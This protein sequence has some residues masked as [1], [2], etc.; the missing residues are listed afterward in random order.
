[1]LSI[2]LALAP[3]LAPALAPR[4]PDDVLA[5]VPQPVS[6]Q[7][8]AGTFTL[9]AQTQVLTE[10][11]DIGARSAAAAFVIAA[12][13]S[14]GLALPVHDLQGEAPA[15]ALLFTR[16]GGDA[17]LGLEGYTLE[18]SDAGAV[19]RSTGAAGLLHGAETLLQLFPPE[20]YARERQSGVAWSAPG[21]LIRDQP[22]FA[23]RG[24]LLDVSR[25]FM[26]KDEVKRILDQ[27]ALH[28]LNVFHWH[29]VDDHG[30]RIEIKAYP[31][32]TEVGAWRSAIGF[33]LDPKASSAYDKAGRYGGFYTQEDI[34]EIV[35]FAT[36]RAIT[37]VPEIEMPGHSVAA[38][39]A[40][41]Q[42]SCGG[43]PFDVDV[44][45]GVH[46]GIFCPGNEAT[47]GFLQ[48]VLSE[49]CALFPGTFVHLGGDEV[50]REEWQKCPRCLERMKNEKLADPAELQ[51]WFLKRIEKFVNAKGKRVIGWDEI[52]EGGLAPNAA[53]MSWRG[54]QGGLAAA[55]A[56][57]DVV[58]C[59]NESLY[60]DHYQAQGGEP[61]AIGGFTPIEEV[62]GY[63]PVPEG[64]TNAQA[65]H[66]LGAQG[67]LWTEYVPNAAHAEY[68][69][70]PR[71][72]AVAEICWTPRERKDLADFM[73]RM[74]I[75]KRR[76]AFLGVHYRPM[77]PPGIE[78][79]LV[80]EGGSP[81]RVH[82]APLI[83]GATV[84]IS[85]DGSDPGKAGTALDGT[86]SLPNGNCRV[87]ARITR[88]DGSES[89]LVEA[90]VVLGKARVRTP[91]GAEGAYQLERAFDL[92]ESSCFWSNRALREGDH[93]TLELFGIRTLK[94]A[95]VTTGDAEKP[96]DNLQRG[97]LEVLAV[98][99]KWL[100]VASFAEG[101]VDCDLPQQP[102][103]AVR[104]RCTESQPYWLRL[105]E[106]TIE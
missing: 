44:P 104:I 97:V 99:G 96:D 80:F 93:V 65:R 57:H 91:L 19:V 43:G 48:D 17:K 98:D 72:C 94:H 24:L 5:L 14:T 81:P 73:R 38:L 28:K 92:D 89:F 51:S 100:E 52:L 56:G 62:Y 47:F 63:E 2:V 11:G 21:V 49:V 95:R 79:A 34:R 69:L 87:R 60:L 59:P 26:S 31:K 39:A 61:L 103:R 74:A 50:P 78:D 88:P 105:H 20:L 106:F 66:V 55:S 53:V 30:W 32:L 102:I 41:P 58:M 54:T 77:P 37:V 84:R 1:M 83:P 29:L 7:R 64:L 6:V 13:P 42:F 23:W 8:A 9:D 45:A 16:T 36:A 86:L 33:G 22:R 82:V 35:A 18:V 70:W 101:K 40:Y 75:H 15:N 67:N 46:A 71:A 90:L 3:S 85:F 25:H 10:A 76:L 68:M 12:R 27:M 4:A